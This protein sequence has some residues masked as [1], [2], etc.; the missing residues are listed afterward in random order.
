MGTLILLTVN[1]DVLEAGGLASFNTRN[2]QMFYTSL[3]V[4]FQYRWKNDGND[5]V[6]PDGK[7]SIR[8]LFFIPVS[9]I[10]ANQVSGNI[11]PHSTRLF[12]IDW[13]KNPQDK[14]FV[15]PESFF[16]GYF[17]DVSYQWNNF[18]VG[19]YLAHLDLSYGAAG[20]HSTKNTIF[21]VF[22][23]QLLICIFIALIIIF[24]VGKKFLKS[25]NAKII[26]KARL[27]MST[28]S[29]ANHG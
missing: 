15:R 28:P 27:G 2:K 20:I 17:S 10:D 9:K 14:N 19:P 25:Y 5:R 24:F 4:S 12:D 23:W 29:D 26:E 18:A 8:S 7:I 1:G 21:F 22:P 16:K 11:L 6:K 13:V 3:P